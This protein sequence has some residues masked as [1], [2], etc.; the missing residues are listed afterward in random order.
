M[1]YDTTA[2]SYRYKGVQAALPL[3]GTLND[4]F[5][6]FSPTAHGIGGFHQRLDGGIV[7]RDFERFI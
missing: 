1:D 7:R 6:T 4:H 3:Q 2:E 5:T